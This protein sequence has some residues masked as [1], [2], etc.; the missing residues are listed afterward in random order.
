MLQQL[1]AHS[2]F[3]T[4]SAQLKAKP[5][6]RALHPLGMA[7]V[8]TQACNPSCHLDTLILRSI[9]R[10]THTCRHQAGACVVQGSG[11]GHIQDVGRFNV[12]AEEG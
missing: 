9:C 12:Q 3:Q 5:W 11:C 10:G 2:P 8:H 7:P 4:L 6:L 1:P